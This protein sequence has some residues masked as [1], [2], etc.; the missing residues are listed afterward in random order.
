MKSEA[1]IKFKIKIVLWA[2]IRR[3]GTGTSPL[4]LLVPNCMF[5]YIRCLSEYSLGI[6]EKGIAFK[7]M[8]S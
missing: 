1:F 4:E 6:Y 7:Y 8:L 5:V 2:S 3:N